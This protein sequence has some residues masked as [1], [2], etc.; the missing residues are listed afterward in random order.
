MLIQI[1]KNGTVQKNI[2]LPNRTPINFDIID[3]K[4]AIVLNTGELLIYDLNKVPNLKF[5]SLLGNNTSSLINEN[6]PDNTDT[7]NFNNNTT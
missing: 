3:N 2:E 7:M 4:I 6:Y 5:D 1:D